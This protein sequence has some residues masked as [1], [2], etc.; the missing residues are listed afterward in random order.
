MGFV[1]LQIVNKIDGELAFLL[2][3]LCIFR[4]ASFL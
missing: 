1:Y 2:F 3:I 4:R